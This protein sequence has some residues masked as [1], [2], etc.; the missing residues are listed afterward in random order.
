MPK[1]EV[2]KK[3]LK[4]FGVWNHP[5]EGAETGPRRMYR[6]SQSNIRYGSRLCENAAIESFCELTRRVFQ[7]VVEESAIADGGVTSRE[8]DRM[9][10]FRNPSVSCAATA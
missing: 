7:S 5:I 4:Y 10:E 6:G 3:L 9:A 2:G 8:F 1:R